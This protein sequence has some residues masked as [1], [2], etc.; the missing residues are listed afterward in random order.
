MKTTIKIILRF[1][2]PIIQVGIFW[3]SNFIPNLFFHFDKRPLVIIIDRLIIRTLENRKLQG[4]GILDL[5]DNLF[6]AF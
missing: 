4:S 3:G 2:D 6:G 5:L 1:T